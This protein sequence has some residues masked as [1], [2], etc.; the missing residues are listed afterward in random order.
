MHPAHRLKLETSVLHRQVD[1][2]PLMKRLMAKDLS[3]L[4]YQL[5]LQLLLKWLEQLQPVLNSLSLADHYAT[6]HKINWLSADLHV[7]SGMELLSSSLINSDTYICSNSHTAT[8]ADADSVLHTNENLI[9]LPI[10]KMAKASRAFALG[11]HYV[12]EGSTLG[13][14]FI[15]PRVEQSLG[16]NDVTRFYRGYGH[17]LMSRWRNTQDTLNSEL[18]GDEALQ[19]A[20][21]GAQGAF[22]LMLDTFKF[23]MHHNLLDNKQAVS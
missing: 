7:L 20:I 15:A 22:G 14:Q 3:C 9:L 10:P 19:L 6:H 2:H 17:N 16:R 18:V 11:I 13:A 23:P 12:V 4:E 1:R 21:S 5:I 8:T